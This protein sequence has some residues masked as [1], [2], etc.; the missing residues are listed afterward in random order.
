MPRAMKLTIAILSAILFVMLIVIA[1][2]LDLTKY[3]HITDYLGV[4]V[5]LI[6]AFVVYFFP[7]IVADRRGHRDRTAITIVNLFL[8]WTFL[9]WVG[10]LAWACTSNTDANHERDRRPSSPPQPQQ[11]VYHYPYY[12]PQPPAQP[13]TRNR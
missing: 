7:S 10:S 12:P 2:T 1:L 13:A 3:D 11:P 4:I 9:G 5:L 8:G 6:A